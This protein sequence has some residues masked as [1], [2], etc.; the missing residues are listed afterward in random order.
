MIAAPPTIEGGLAFEAP[1]GFRR[2]STTVTLRV[3]PG[4]GFDEA[5]L[6]SPVRPNLIVNRRPAPAAGLAACV[7]RV[8]EDLLR[9]IPGIRAIDAADVRFADGAV[10]VVLGYTYP[11]PRVAGVILCQLQALRL[12]GET[13]SSLTVT[14][15]LSHLTETRRDQFLKVLVSA[16]LAAPGEPNLETGRAT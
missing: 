3:A 5:G 11:A 14:T 2:E 9:T 7:A 10:G 8:E 15:T 6:R 4:A 16:R 13:L 12:D 1:P